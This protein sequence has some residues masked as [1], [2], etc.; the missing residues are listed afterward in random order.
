[1][2]QFYG[3]GPR[4]A[5]KVVALDVLTL[6]RHAPHGR[7]TAPDEELEAISRRRPARRDLR[8]AARPARPYGRRDPRALP[9]DPAAR[10][11]L[12]PRRA[13][14]RSTA[15]TSPRARRHRGNVR[16][17]ARGDGAADRHPARRARCSCSATRTRTWPRDHVPLVMSH[18]P[19][20]VEGVDDDARSRT[21]PSSSMHGRR[22]RRC[23]PDGRGWLLVELGG[24]TK[25]E[26]DEKAHDLMATLKTDGVPPSDMKLYDDPRAGAARSGRCARPASA[27]P[28]SSPGKPDTYEGWEDSAVPPEQLG[29]YLR[30]LQKLADEYGYHAALYGHYGQGCVHA[31]LQLR[32]RRAPT[33]SRR[34]ALPRRGVRP[35]RLELGGSL[36][37]EHGDGQ[38]R[39]ELLPKMF[40][41]EL[42]DAF[43]EL[44]GDLGSGLEDEPGQDGRP[45]PDRRRTCASGRATA[46]RR[47]RRTSPS[48]RIAA[49]FAHAT[50]RCVG[51]RQLP[52]HRGEGGVM[53]PSYMVTREEKHSTRGRAHLLW[54]ML[55]SDELET[56]WRRRGLEALDLCLSCKGCTQRLPGA[57]S[58]CRRYKAEF[59]S[60]YY[61]GQPRPRH[62]YAFGLDRQGGR[63]SRARARAREL[64][65][66]DAGPVARSRSGSPASRRS[67]SCRRSPSDAAAVVPRPR[68]AQRRR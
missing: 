41:E 60:H 8:G 45:V 26:A 13:A 39:A 14:A 17:D 52:P 20:G 1:M 44:Q 40:G 30:D 28:P 46:R 35:R 50:T 24:D 48:R 37:G 58:T 12:Q 15:S 65:H 19:L 11:R 5:D 7:R 9:G 49:S 57:T 66:A 38:S 64:R 4:T 36:S 34:S 10:L 56:V 43:R 2:A 25:E 3:P 68:R 21:W 16:H 18:K 54:E 63:A 53:C 22:S 42:V 31:A 61:A 23:C 47:S 33:G 62:A 32:P 55:N 67:G 51:D 59:L 6:R 27:R 29:D